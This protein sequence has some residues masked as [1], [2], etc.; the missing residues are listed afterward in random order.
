MAAMAKLADRPVYALTESFKF[1]RIL[2]VRLNSFSDIANLLVSP[3]NQYDLPIAVPVLRFPD[4]TVKQ[5]QDE[6]KAT[7][8]PST[9]YRPFVDSATPDAL[10]MTAEQIQNNPLIDYTTPDLVTL[11][12]SDVG[13]LTPSVSW[14]NHTEESS[15]NALR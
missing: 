3:L 6:R 10:Q 2:W 12:I 8:I 4:H 1:L 13:I 14:D 11:I 7:K 15:A 5:E 9:P